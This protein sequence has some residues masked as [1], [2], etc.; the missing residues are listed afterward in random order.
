MLQRRKWKNLE[1]FRYDSS[2]RYVGD[3]SSRLEIYHDIFRVDS[4]CIVQLFEANR[5]ES[6]S[7]FDTFDLYRSVSCNCS[8]RIEVNRKVISIRSIWIEVYHDKFRF[9]FF[10][11]FDTFDTLRDDSKCIVI[12]F[13]SVSYRELPRQNYSLPTVTQEALRQQSKSWI[14]THP[15][16]TGAL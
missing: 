12:R 10:D 11:N 4:K 13:E 14:S 5:S 1:K 2:I 16:F 3:I 6:K 15:F 9:L 8:R 7:N